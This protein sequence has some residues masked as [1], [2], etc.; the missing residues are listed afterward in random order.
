MRMVSPDFEV[1]GHP[2]GKTVENP[3][4]IIGYHRLHRKPEPGCMVSGCILHII[5]KRREQ[6]MPVGIYFKS[7]DRERFGPHKVTGS[8][9]M[10]MVIDV[11]LYHPIY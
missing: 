1:T 5:G 7:F 10:A 2:D 4:L 11:Q 3:P 9:G 6:N 8:V